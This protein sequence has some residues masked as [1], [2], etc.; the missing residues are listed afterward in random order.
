MDLKHE[1][2]LMT[3]ADAQ[4]CLN[5]ILKGWIATEE[6]YAEVVASKQEMTTVILTTA[7]ELGQPLPA[8][9]DRMPMDQ[10]R[11]IRVILVAI[12]DDLALSP[13]LE[14]WLRTQRPKL[15]EPVTTALV[16]A[17]ITFLLSVHV[18]VDYESQDGSRKLKIQVEKKP[19]SETIIGKFFRIFH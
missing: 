19:T 14:A 1:I 13:R 12:A 7:Q 18:K 5:G 8:E 11:A 4:N 17:G 16:L 3:D 9:I 15:I 6:V 2:A 10:T